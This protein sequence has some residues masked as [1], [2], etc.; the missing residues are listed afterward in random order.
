MA[1]AVRCQ[2]DCTLGSQRRT[3]GGGWSCR[4]THAHANDSI[5]PIVRWLQS[6]GPGCERVQKEEICPPMHGN[7]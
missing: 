7:A 4:P 5:S 2:S 1:V 3:E 6:S